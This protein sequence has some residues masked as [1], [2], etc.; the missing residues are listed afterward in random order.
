[1]FTENGDDTWTVRFETNG[2]TDYVTLIEISLRMVQEITFM[3]MMVL[4]VSNQSL[5]TTNCGLL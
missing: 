2:K 4:L 3:Q 1:M 5:E